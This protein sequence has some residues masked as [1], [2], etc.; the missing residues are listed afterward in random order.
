MVDRSIAKNKITVLA[1]LFT[2][3]C[4]GIALYGVWLRFRFLER[5]MRSDE[6]NTFLRFASSSFWNSVSNYSLPNNH[7]LNSVLINCS[8]RIFGAEPWA[9]RLPAFIAGMVLIPLTYLVMRRL[10]GNLQAFCAALLVSI[11]PTLIDF[12]VNARGYTLAADIF[13]IQLASVVRLQEKRRYSWLITFAVLSALGMWT[14]PSYLFAL[15]ALWVFL[16]WE[17]Y[18]NKTGEFSGS[19]LKLVGCGLLT[20]LLTFALYS[21]VIFTLGLSALT[22]NQFVTPVET[23]KLFERLL[24]VP[25]NY[26]MLITWGF[27]LLMKILFG[28][29]A[30]LMILSYSKVQPNFIKLL[31]SVVLCV[32]AV[33]ALKQRVPPQR[34]WVMFLPLGY[35]VVSLGVVAIAQYLPRPQI[36]YLFLAIFM[37]IA[38]A[39]PSATMILRSSQ[40]GRALGSSE[41]ADKIAQIGDDAPRYILSLSIFGATLEY[42]LKRNGAS[43]QFTIVNHFYGLPPGVDLL[44]AEQVLV[45]GR[46]SYSIPE[47]KKHYTKLVFPDKS[48]CLRRLSTHQEISIFALAFRECPQGAL[49]IEIR[50]KKKS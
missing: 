5:A 22:D 1:V 50:W 31:V 9:I 44:Q 24:L 34:T 4:A 2:A 28:I 40:T 13:L 38:L 8:T 7:I 30:I 33:I 11:S 19:F 46:Y 25:L 6:T 15:G 45:I 49:P 17:V 21:P 41:A 32:V 23:L 3:Y 43:K 27:P 26:I 16:L 39:C 14:V 20:G 47:L 10:I 36:R 48:M 12:S 37:G 42:Y 35:C 29:F 18:Q